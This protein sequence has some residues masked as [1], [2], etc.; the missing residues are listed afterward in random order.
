MSKLV[1]LSLI[2]FFY[3]DILLD[4]LFYSL[5]KL[6]YNLHVHMRK[7]IYTCKH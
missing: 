3:V 6:K 4:N 7:R 2:S 1:P 5:Y